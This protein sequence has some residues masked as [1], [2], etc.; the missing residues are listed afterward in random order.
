MKMKVVDVIRKTSDEQIANIIGAVI[1]RHTDGISAEE[2]VKM[3]FPN[4]LKELQREIEIDYKQ[5][6]ADRI[7]SMSDEELAELIA[8]GE[9]CAICPLCKYYGTEN[10]YMENEGV[11]KN[12]ASGI[13]EWLKS[14][15]GETANRDKFRI[16][17]SD[18]QKY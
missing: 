11:H 18:G 5:T 16:A 3:D 2:A 6:N 13:I 17:A 9:L 10:C 8:S 7:R 14:E 1:V 12:C 15:A 4:T